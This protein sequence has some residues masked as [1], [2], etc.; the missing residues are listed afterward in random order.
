MY[1][2]GSA[3]DKEEYA[4]GKVREDLDEVPLGVFC[5]DANG[6]EVEVYVAGTGFR[7]QVFIKNNEGNIIAQNSK[8]F[9]LIP[10]AQEVVNEARCLGGCVANTHTGHS[11]S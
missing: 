7:V 8:P 9:Y 3:F 11:C 6:V 5:E 10:D 1:S 2:T 4:T